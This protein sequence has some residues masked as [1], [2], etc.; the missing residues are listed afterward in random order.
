MPLW[1]EGGQFRELSKAEVAT[2]DANDKTLY[3]AEL[4]KWKVQQAAKPKDDREKMKKI[5]E[6]TEALKIKLQAMDDAK[7]KDAEAG[8]LPQHLVIA[9]PPKALNIRE[10]NVSEW[11]RTMEN[12]CYQRNVRPELEVRTYLG[13]LTDYYKKHVSLDQ[14]ASWEEVK[15]VLMKFQPKGQVSLADLFQVL[16]L[17]DHLVA[18]L[19]KR[20]ISLEAQG[21]SFE[22]A[23]GQLAHILPPRIAELIALQDLKDPEELLS[24]VSALLTTVSRAADTMLTVST[25]TPRGGKAREAKEVT[26]TAP[27]P[28][29]VCRICST[30]GHWIQDCQ[31]EAGKRRYENFR[32]ATQKIRDD[33]PEFAGRGPKRKFGGK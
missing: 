9:H 4:K 12:W 26:R 1:D 5:E 13:D 17:D 29:Y 20:L 22:K 2:L 31:D 24:K 3:E 8:S 7:V 32:L 21:I 23:R 30:P 27:P 15:K 6:E 28:G 18:N 10:D 19:A 11:I 16:S 25:S 14:K 33:Y